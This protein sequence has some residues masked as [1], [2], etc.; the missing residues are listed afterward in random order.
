M[1]TAALHVTA[2]DATGL[3][4]KYALPK[5]A[6]V[7]I[8][9][10][11]G[12][13]CALT[14]AVD[15]GMGYAAAAGAYLVLM[16][17]GTAMGGHLWQVWV[18]SPVRKLVGAADGTAYAE[19]QVRLFGRIEAW[20]WPVAALALTWLAPRYLAAPSG[21]AAR[22]EAWALVAAALGLALWAV[23]RRTGRTWLS[24]AATAGLLVAAAALQVWYDRPGDMALLAWRA[25]HLLAVGAWFGGA[26]WNVAIAVRAA[27]E[28]LR[29]PVVIMAHLQLERF[30]AVVRLALPVVLLTGL[31][32]LHDLFAWN[33]GAIQGAFRTLVLVK[34]GLVGLL[35]V[36]FN[37]CPMWHACS[38]I[39]GMCVLDDLPVA[40]TEGDGAS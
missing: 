23:G 15:A 9:G 36:I 4:N 33:A 13:G 25:L 26:V 32:Q 11:A 40:G 17:V 1:A 14:V 21:T 7:V 16:A 38:P 30:R 19:R 31:L 3:L 2:A 18:L 39:A 6:M 10:A 22:A 24:L 28:D 34:L 12:V 8:A 29:T 5:V 20:A 35:V 37:T 27:R